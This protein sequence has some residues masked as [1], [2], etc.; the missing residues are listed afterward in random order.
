[1]KNRKNNP[2]SF[3]ITLTSSKR[4]KSKNSNRCRQI[5][6]DC[7]ENNPP[8]KIEQLSVYEFDCPR[9]KMPQRD[10]LP[11]TPDMF[12]CSSMRLQAF[13]P[14]RVLTKEEERIHK[15]LE[16][17]RSR[18]AASHR[19]SGN[20]SSAVSPATWEFFKVVFFGAFVALKYAFM[21]V[22]V[23]ITIG[24]MICAGRQTSGLR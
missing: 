14:P 10:K 19:T 9:K 21:A 1:M 20:S 2:I 15:E 18:T 4:T 13:P 11:F 8:G 24:C 6:M 22:A 12:N 23:I 3:G 16:R 7:R 5:S 17:F